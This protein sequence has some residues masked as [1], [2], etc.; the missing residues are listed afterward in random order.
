MAAT[1]YAEWLAQR[2]TG[3]AIP[4]GTYNQGL[5]VL[6]GDKVRGMSANN[7]NAA[8]IA[9]LQLGYAPAVPG[10]RMDE[11]RQWLLGRGAPAGTIADMRQYCVLNS[12]MP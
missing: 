3:L 2:A 1:T 8:T 10:T 12:L 4:Y 7:I 9:D 5:K 11:E 6:W